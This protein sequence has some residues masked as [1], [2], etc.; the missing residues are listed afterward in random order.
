MV[1]GVVELDAQFVHV[2]GQMKEPVLSTHGADEAVAGA[3][4]RIRA[5]LRPTKSL[6]GRPVCRSRPASGWG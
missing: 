4:L 6:T 3:R 5:R 2:W 1:G